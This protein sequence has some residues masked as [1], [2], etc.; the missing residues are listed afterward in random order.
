MSKCVFCGTEMVN[1]VCPNE[2]LHVKGMCLNCNSCW[3]VDNDNDDGESY[4]CINEENKEDALNK[5]M[6][7]IQAPAGYTI[8]SLELSPV[9]LKDVTKKCRRYQMNKELLMAA[10]KTKLDN[11]L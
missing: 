2:E 4:V 3:K 8:K 7:S 5:V 11:N 6:G 10:F 1:G 9:P